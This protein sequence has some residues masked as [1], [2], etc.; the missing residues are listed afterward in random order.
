MHQH[1]VLFFF[2]C[3][4]FKFL[5]IFVVS[6][7]APVMGKVVS[8][9]AR[10]RFG[11]RTYRRIRRAIGKDIVES[12]NRHGSRARVCPKCSE[13]I[14]CVSMCGNLRYRRCLMM[15]D[16]FWCILLLHDAEICWNFNI[17]KPFP[18]AI[19]CRSSKMQRAMVKPKCKASLH[20]NAVCMVNQYWKHLKTSEYSFFFLSWCIYLLFDSF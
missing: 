5:C 15:F 19:Q 20:Y 9:S 1:F 3:Y 4:F 11:K 12:D 13:L 6:C 2:V 18:V 17:F 10:P 16:A 14:L 8:A 7:S